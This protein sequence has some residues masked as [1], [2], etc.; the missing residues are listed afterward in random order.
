MGLFYIPKSIRARPNMNNGRF[1]LPIILFV[2]LFAVFAIGGCAT[3]PPPQRAK[4]PS[5]PPKVKLATL[6]EAL[7][8]YRAIQARGG[9]VRLPEVSKLERGV[10]GE[11]IAL[12]RG[13]LVATGDLAKGKAQGTLYDEDVAAAVGRFQARHGLEPDGTVGKDTLQALNVPVEDRIRQLETNIRKR[14][15]GPAA[16]RAVVVNI[17][18]FR[19]KVLD[20]GKPVLAMKVVVGQ[21]RQWQTPLLE[22]QIK[23][24]VLNPK[25]NVPPGIFAKELIHHLRR[26][27]TYLQR[28]GMQV[29][30]TAE[31][32][33]FDPATIDWSQVSATNPR[34]RI[35]QREGAGNSLGRIKF[36]F[37]N[38]HDVYLHDTPQ[39]KF[40]ERNM[41]ALS[42]GCVRVERPLELA[43]VLMRDDPTW[44]RARIETAINSGRN[45]HVPLSVP[46]PVSIIYRTAWV[47]EAGN[48]HFRNDIYDRDAGAAPEVAPAGRAF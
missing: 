32:Q 36:L 44:S 40:F 31:T 11:T 46:V 10:E 12:L 45:Q 27:P 14:Q 29:I 18:D 30:P 7:E 38:P 26:D 4:A 33:G 6:E 42:H 23:Y 41:R 24:L 47:D 8:E 25:W 2:S 48:V 21:R 9:W 17:P 28:H 1:R 34:V 43:E 19:L 22:S 13:R 37:P 20:H 39:K 15:D 16:E 3:K 35:V 5:P